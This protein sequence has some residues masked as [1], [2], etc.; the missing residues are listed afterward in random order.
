MAHYCDVTG[1]GLVNY[2]SKHQM[3]CI[4]FL[5]RVKLGKKNVVGYFSGM[6]FYQNLCR[7]E[8]NERPFRE[9][10]LSRSLKDVQTCSVHISEGVKVS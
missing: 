4:S 6:L 5:S 1:V 10:A 9:W 7:R 8:H 2:T 3:A